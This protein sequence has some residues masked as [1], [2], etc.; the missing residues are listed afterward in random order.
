MAKLLSFF[1]YD[2][3]KNPHFVILRFKPTAELFRLTPRVMQLQGD[4]YLLDLKSSFDYWEKIARYRAQKIGDLIEE[5][6][7]HTYGKEQVIVVCEHPFQGYLLHQFLEQKESSGIFYTDARI[8]LN[9][10]RALSWAHWSECARDFHQFFEE[11]KVLT[12]E[13]KKASSELK[14]LEKLVISLGV[15][16]LGEMEQVD[17][18]D[19]QRRFS[20]FIGL[21]W[22]WT[23][24][25]KFE[26]ENDM[27]L[28]NFALDV[29]ILD[30]PWIQFNLRENPLIQVHLEFPLTE[31]DHLKPELENS[32]IKL[33]RIRELRSPYRIVEFVWSLTLYDLECC[34]LPIHFKFPIDM[35]QEKEE[36]FESLMVQ[37]QFAFE[38]LNQK[39]KH[40]YEDTDHVNAAYI[41]G[42][43]LEVSQTIFPTLSNNELFDQW[44]SG[45]LKFEEFQNKVKH[46]LNRYIVLD[47]PIPSLNFQLYKKE[48]SSLPQV[49]RVQPFHL[50]PSPQEF[51]E[52]QIECKRFIERT[53]SNW[54]DEEDE[55]SHF[56]DYYMCQVEG[57][58]IYAFKDYKGKWF[59]HGLFS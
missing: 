34:R 30:F 51:L 43:Q 33:S 47:I 41:I 1:Q 13:R 17:F 27:P 23:Y 14:R 15:K 7:L 21:L 55:Q 6:L 37:F 58:I 12:S 49:Y 3:K 19:L 2:K 36:D 11:H 20:K 28:L 9:I 38:E 46:P 54:W 45:K 22:Q 42:W 39:L 35:E 8:S 40:K 57:Q 29:A 4:L 32:F 26:K 31:W 52:A 59:K 53:S 25:G 10:Y 5:T 56:R 18:E 16:N 50:L 48:E 44:K 24:P